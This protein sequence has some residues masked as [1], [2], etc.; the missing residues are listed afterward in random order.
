MMEGADKL[1][2]WLADKEDIAFRNGVK[3]AC[4]NILNKCDRESMPVLL[5]QGDDTFYVSMQEVNEIINTV[6]GNTI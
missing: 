3:W 6:G 2:S 1:R 4:E 5:S